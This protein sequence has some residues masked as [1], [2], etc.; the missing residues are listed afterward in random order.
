MMTRRYDL[1]LHTEVSPCS[2]SSPDDIVEAALNR[3][4]DGVAVTDHD[5][6]TGARA[7]ADTAPPELEVIVGA[8]ITTSQGHLLALDVQETPDPEI[9]PLDAIEFV[10]DRGGISVLAHPF[11]RLRQTYGNKL[12]AIA[13]AVDGVEVKN[14]RC[15]L[16]RYNRRAHRFAEEHGLSMT[17]GSD[18]HFPHEVGRAVTLSEGPVLEAIRCETT[19]VTGDD[20]YVSGHALTKLNDFAS[21]LGLA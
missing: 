1:H 17:G 6:V 16:S 5:T 20:G 21:I 3:N 7:V 18:G 2:R 9:A 12:D 13:G 10:R 14:S 19:N 4:L 15:L 8:E 11:D